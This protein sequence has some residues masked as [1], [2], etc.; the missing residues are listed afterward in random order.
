MAAAAARS[1]SPSA[2]ASDLSRVSQGGDDQLPSPN[3]TERMLDIFP[4]SDFPDL[5][6]QGF[7]SGNGLGELGGLGP[8][9]EDN[10]GL[11]MDSCLGSFDLFQQMLNPGP[12]LTTQSLTQTQAQTRPQAQMLTPKDQLP[13]GAC[14]R[15]KDKAPS[16]YLPSPE[17]QDVPSPQ[18]PWPIDQ[19][20][21]PAQELVLP[22]LNRNSHHPG[23]HFSTPHVD[24]S[25]WAAL[26]RLVQTPSE[27]SPW[28]SI[29]LS[30]F[31][32]EETIDLCIDLYFAHFHQVSFGSAAP[33]RA[34]MLLLTYS[35]SKTDV[36]NH[37]PPDICS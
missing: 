36:P 1:P 12:D 6:G 15:S 24:H 29:D 13:P 34:T 14:L 31:P 37:P 22:P 9:F 20:V 16:D 35:L 21:G 4:T 11:W 18:D 25:V 10:G 26:Q 2:W 3:A 23:K 32:D 17:Y 28:P 7:G 27:Q 8:E 5:Q 30:V 19:H 33:G